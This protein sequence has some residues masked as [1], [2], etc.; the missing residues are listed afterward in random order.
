MSTMQY[1]ERRF[2]EYKKEAD[3]VAELEK[4]RAAWHKVKYVAT[5]KLYDVTVEM[6]K[7]EKNL[8][9]MVRKG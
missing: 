8:V 6:N 1:Y 7:A 9:D 2:T 4:R 3:R 5:K